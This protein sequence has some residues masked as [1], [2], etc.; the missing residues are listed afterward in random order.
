MGSS[1]RGIQL[2]AR[3]YNFLRYFTDWWA[4]IVL[5]CLLIYARMWRLN[6]YCANSVVNEPSDKI[7]CSKFMGGHTDERFFTDHVFV[8]T[9]LE[10]A[11]IFLLILF[12]PRLLLACMNFYYRSKNN[13]DLIVDR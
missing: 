10:Q 6:Y 11:A 5:A 9:T 2:I 12:A 3:F 8:H 1:E 7:R 4:L 13:S